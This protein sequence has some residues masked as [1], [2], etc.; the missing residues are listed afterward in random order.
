M[1]KIRKNRRSKLA[2][3]EIIGA[4]LLI[5]V[6]LVI[7]FAAWAWASG[8]AA[9]S[10]SSLGN[11]VSCNILYMK[12]NFVI[13]N[14]NFSS[15]NSEKVTVWFYNNGNTTVYIQDLWIS[16]SSWSSNP[17]T[18]TSQ[19][20]T[21]NSGTSTYLTSIPAGNVSALTVQS[22]TALTSGS[23]YQFK[24]LGVYGNTYTFQQ[25]K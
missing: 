14:A 6:T 8:A 12:E 25:A 16:N 1:K 4:I 23:T 18:G 7:G 5:A 9:S 22:S 20:N 2:V 15:T 19:I 10:E 3:S 13:V 17:F 24:A 11:S 21:C